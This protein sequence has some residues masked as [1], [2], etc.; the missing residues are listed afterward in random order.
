MEMQTNSLTNLESLHK[1]TK[2][3]AEKMNH[4]QVT[5]QDNSTA[6]SAVG[7]HI[8]ALSDQIN[9]IQSS[10]REV[11]NI[12]MQVK[13]LSLNAAIEAARAGEAGKGFAVVAT[14]IGNLSDNTDH[15]VH[16]IEDSIHKMSNLLNKTISD[17]N[18]A[19][20]I[21]AQFENKLAECVDE[22]N[23]IAVQLSQIIS[24]L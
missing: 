13:I 1:E 12:S 9:T 23:K 24:T 15:A 11:Q 21:G 22:S 6:R 17:M 14:E 8:A 7:K 10:L 3:F 2:T 18:S 4:T 20:E 16:G 19:K 5:F